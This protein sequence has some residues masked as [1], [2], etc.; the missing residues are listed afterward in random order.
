MIPQVK[1]RAAI[2]TI[3]ERRDG[4]QIRS[5][6]VGF[7]RDAETARNEAVMA[8]HPAW[9]AFRGGQQARFPHCGAALQEKKLALHPVFQYTYARAER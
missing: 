7:L 8:D 2:R 6:P 3:A 5:L 9:R 1:R 4:V